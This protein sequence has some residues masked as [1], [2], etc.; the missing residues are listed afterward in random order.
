MSTIDHRLLPT[1]THHGLH[2]THQLTGRGG[3]LDPAAGWKTLLHTCEETGFEQSSRDL[4]AKAAEPH[5]LL[6]R[7]GDFQFHVRQFIPFDQGSRALEHPNPSQTPPTNNARAIQIEIADFAIGRLRQVGGRTVGH[8]W[9]DQTYDALAK[10]MLM[11]EHRVPVP[12]HRPRPFSQDPHRFAPDE[13]VGV[14]GIVGHEHAPNQPSGH[15]DP[16]NL[17]AIYLISRMDHY[18]REIIR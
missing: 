7:V 1:G 6:G 16:G 18:A 9:D 17:R 4:L 13:F 2:I 3:P 12:R 5:L 10:L 15:W 11:I 14:R 8:D